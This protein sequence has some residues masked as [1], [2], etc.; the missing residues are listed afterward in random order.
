MPI[1]EYECQNCGQ[2]FEL[3]L[4]LQNND[5]AKCPNCDSEEVERVISPFTTNRSV[6]RPTHE[7][8]RGS[9]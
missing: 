3:Y 1:Y 6:Y 2:R 5:P 4:S 8:P 9:G 7:R